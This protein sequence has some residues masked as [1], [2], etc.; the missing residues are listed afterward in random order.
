MPIRL[1]A[2]EVSSQIA[3][4]EV[5]ERPASVVKEL[6]ENSLDADAKNI[7]ISIA[8]AG[9][10]LIEVADDGH[11]IPPGELELAASRHATSKLIL[12]EDLFHI[13]TLGFRGEALASIGSVS[14]MTITSR[15]ASAR[16]GARLKVEGGAAGKVEKVGA[17]PGTVVR[18][19]N[20]FYNVPARLKFLK[21]DTTERRAIDSL[22]TRYALAYPNVRFKVTDGKQVTL[23][24][25]GDG[26]R[27]AILAALYGV[28]VARQM[29]EVMAAEEGM[30]LSGFISPVS[31]TRSNRRE[32]T[33]FINGRWVQEVSLNSALLQAYHT[34][35]MVGRYPLTALF[36]DMP[37]EEVDV[38]VHPTKAEVRFRSQ[39]R[40]FSFVQ[41]SVRKA[42]LA[43]APVPSVAP[44]LW[45]ARAAPVERR[46]VGI[47][48]SI[49]HDSVSG[50][51]SP[52]DRSESPITN[53]H[54]PDRQKS[55]AAGVPL[56][57]LVG[58]IGATYLVAEGPDGLYLI[59]QHAAHERVL[60]EKLMAQREAQSIPSQSLLA[61]QVVTLPPQSAKA[62]LDSLSFL[63][64]FGFE[65][66]EFGT[67]T[68]QVR[69]MPALFSGGDAA[70]ALRALV[71]DFE[72]DE[73]PLQAE[74]EARLAA[75]V[76]KRLAVKAGQALTP[77]E[78][79]SLLNDLEACQSPRTC[80]HG[81]PTMIHLSVDMLE[82]QFGRKGA[83]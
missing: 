70:A 10:T 60:F 59:D 49:A 37:P 68:F 52:V 72:E 30:T 81:R 41:R 39:D 71:E 7:S 62:L 78:Q 25:A 42:L 38:N 73:S 13:R 34:L 11:G 22:V 50:D 12:S 44:Q 48:W 57:R 74:M 55:F 36:L 67:N 9:R 58:Q 56:L 26:D 14:Q 43:Y 64:R 3:A 35:L 23:Q 17:P 4:G 6:I 76:C 69:A 21:T 5:V 82:R 1:L 27:R 63:N 28:D 32:I 29:L 47:D 61:P 83:R 54:S 65:V 77:E 80:P 8:D 33:F 2:P 45:G 46:E 53:Y 66:E 40:V 19:E 51:Q 75:R 18:V 20:L 16:E 79:R 15:V 24:T 31:L